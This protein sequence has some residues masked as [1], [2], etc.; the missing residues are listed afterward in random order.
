MSTKI[1]KHTLSV[2]VSVYTHKPILSPLQTELNT[3]SQRDSR[4]NPYQQPWRPA[5]WRSV[6]SVTALQLRGPLGGG[7]KRDK[8]LPPMCL[9][10]RSCGPSQSG[11]RH[12]TSLRATQGRFLLEQILSSTT[13]HFLLLLLHFAA[14]T[15]R[16]SVKAK[17]TDFPPQPLGTEDLASGMFPGPT[18]PRRYF[19][20]CLNFI[21]IM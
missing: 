8:A 3:L 13:R 14:F 10:V 5:A 11:G 19:S 9:L 18:T 16:D 21:L 1:Y 15:A 2:P 17:S 6:S 20:K 7:Y 12:N 4:D